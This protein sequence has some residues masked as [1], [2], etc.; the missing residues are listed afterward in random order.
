MW[1]PAAGHGEADDSR[2]W[3]QPTEQSFHGRFAPR[4]AEAKEPLQWDR[5]CWAPTRFLTSGSLYLL[6]A[7]NVAHVIAVSPSAVQS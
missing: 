2:F 7:I 4:P 5:G 6:S 1:L 3:A